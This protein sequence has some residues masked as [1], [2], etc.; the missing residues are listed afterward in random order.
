M[1]IHFIGSISLVNSNNYFTHISELQ[2]THKFK[3]RMFI[4]EK[5]SQPLHAIV[6]ILV[7]TLVSHTGH[8]EK[9]ER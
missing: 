8:Q 9:Q 3:N 7:L 2:C 1:Y 5:K 6:L 4:I